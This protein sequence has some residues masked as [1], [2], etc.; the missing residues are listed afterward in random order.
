MKYL[1][2]GRLNIDFPKIAELIF[3]PYYFLFVCL[4]FSFLGVLQCRM[5]GAQSYGMMPVKLSGDPEK[6]TVILT[7]VITEGFLE[8]L[9]CEQ[10]RQEVDF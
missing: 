3:E 6:Q 2:F 7:S 1:K 4:R 5:W 10:D 8:N 9:S